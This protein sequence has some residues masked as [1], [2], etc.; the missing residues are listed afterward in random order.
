LLGLCEGLIAVGDWEHANVVRCCAMYTGVYSFA[1]CCC[2][3]I[4]SHLPALYAPSYEALRELMLDVI[5]V[6]VEPF[7]RSM[8]AFKVLHD[9]CYPFTWATAFTL[10][11]YLNNVWGDNLQYFGC[12]PTEPRFRAHRLSY[13]PSSSVTRR[14]CLATISPSLAWKSCRCCIAWACLSVVT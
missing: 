10:N 4:M 1:N 13:K 11:T 3:Q 8:A 12:L 2:Q 5:H 7:Y 9:R 6:K 14:C